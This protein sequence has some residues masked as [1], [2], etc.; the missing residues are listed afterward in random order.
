MI[1][2]FPEANRADLQ[3]NVRIGNRLQ[4]IARLLEKELHKAG[5]TKDQAQFSLLIWGPGRMQY[6]SNAD[7]SGVKAAMEEMIAKWDNDG[8]DL[9]KP[10]LP[11]GGMDYE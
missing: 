7:R 8:Q 1:S 9:G 6:I 10:H 4:R 2:E 5:A 11:L 3:L